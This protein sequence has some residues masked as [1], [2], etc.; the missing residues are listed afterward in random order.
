[1]ILR[2][3]LNGRYRF[4]GVDLRRSIWIGRA[5]INPS[6]LN[7]RRWLLIGRHTLHAVSDVRT[8]NLNLGFT[9]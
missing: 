5:E 8:S 3:G 6:V 9:I 2:L 7:P 4:G 1:M